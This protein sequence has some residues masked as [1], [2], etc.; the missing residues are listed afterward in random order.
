MK[1]IVR[2]ILEGEHGWGRVE[3][4]PVG[5][6]VWSRY[7]VAVFPPGL[8]RSELRSLN[9]YYSWPIAGALAAVFAF[10]ALGSTWPVVLDV[11]AVAAVYSGV[12]W[13]AATLT[14][15]LRSRIRRVAAVIVQLEGR[16][17]TYGEADILFATLDGF[18]E[19][20]ARQQA[21]AVTPAQYEAGWAQLYDAIPSGEPRAIEARA[22]R[23]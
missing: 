7:R 6:T 5:R 22:K 9:F 19:L 14:R 21:K 23:S 15:D 10:A 20:D 13:G 17:E 11:L 2:R 16:Y 3:V 8:S 18:S 4:A 12:F 1:N